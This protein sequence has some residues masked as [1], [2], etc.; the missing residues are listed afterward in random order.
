MSEAFIHKVVLPGS[1]TTK[2]NPFALSALLAESI[3]VYY[4]CEL[5]TEGRPM[6]LCLIGQRGLVEYA[7]RAYAAVH[8]LIEKQVSMLAETEGFKFGTVV[9][10]R[11]ALHA[12]RSN[13]QRT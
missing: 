1:W 8:A 9:A 2:T 10:L 5:F 12:R 6:R 3:G 4:W 7:G 13:E 11:D